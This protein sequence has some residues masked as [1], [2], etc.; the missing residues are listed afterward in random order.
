VDLPLPDL[1]RLDLPPST[2]FMLGTILTLLAGALVGAAGFAATVHRRQIRRIARLTEQLAR[3]GDPSDLAPGRGIRDRRLR[4]GFEQLGE[5][6]SQTWSLATHD[7]LTGIVNRQTILSR[8]ETEIERAGRY[9]HS[10]SIALLDID[11][12]K[13]INDSYGHTAGDLVLRAV[14]QAIQGSV[15]RV[16]V[17]GRY[18]GEEFVVMLPETD[19]D[20]AARIA[21]KIRRIVGNVQ[22]TLEDGTVVSTTL[23]AGVAGGLGQNLRVDDLISDADAAL[24]T[25]KALG[26]DQ[27]YVFHE[28]DDERLVGRAT[29]AP[30]ARERAI[31]VGRAAMIA[32]TSSLAHALGDHAGEPVVASPMIAESAS[33]VAR[34]IGLPER[35]VERIRT[36]SLLHDLGKL[37]VPDEILKKEGTLD[38]SEWRVVTEHPKIGQVVLEQA[39][40]LRDAATIVLH[41][42][43]WFD[44]RGYPYGL[45]GQQIPVGARIVAVADA[46][47]AMVNGR[48]YRSAMTHDEAIAEL[49]RNAGQQFDPEIVEPF[50]ALFAAGMP[51]TPDWSRAGHELGQ[52]APVGPRNGRATPTHGPIDQRP[53]SVVPA[54]EPAATAAIEAVEP[55]VLGAGALANGPSP[56]S[57]RRTV[58]TE[59]GTRTARSRRLSASA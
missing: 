8:L 11:H 26:R 38:E 23:S 27:V 53:V 42:H 59:G 34:A 57:G 30:A 4:S 22:V 14:A 33:A 32:A 7:P 1:A 2:A 20:A 18:G 6:L 43:E 29:I 3:N 36:A 44:G 55:A 37:A 28:V 25:A 15:R 52:P 16:D 50:V 9:H 24:Y 12:F 41:H 31:A 45:R 35:E 49:R 46:Y 39:G 17:P 19:V 40:A 13:R 51:W 21:E 47:E 48:P 10:L 58:A 5:R 56:K 54:V